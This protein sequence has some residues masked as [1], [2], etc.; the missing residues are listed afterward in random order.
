MS[1]ELFKQLAQSVI[2]G[3]PEDAEALAK[4]ALEEG[5]DAL[6][7]INQGL[8]PGIQKVGELFS[9]GEYFLPEFAFPVEMGNVLGFAKTV[10]HVIRMY[11]DNS[12]SLLQ[13]A[14]K[15]SLFILSTYTPKQEETDV[16]ACWNS[17][18]ENQLS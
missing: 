7:C 2:D 5:V 10:E 8:T 11:N 12:T 3:E 4:K 13:M 18:L 14:N 1:E 15:A 17:I 6:A 16:I 9:T